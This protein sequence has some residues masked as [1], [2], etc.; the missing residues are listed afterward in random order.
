MNSKSAR[1][2]HRTPR[3]IALQ[4]LRTMQATLVELIRPLTQPRTEQVRVPGQLVQGT[5]RVLKPGLDGGWVDEPY[6]YT[7]V[8]WVRR[9]RDPTTLPEN[10]ADYWDGVWRAAQQLRMQA[11][12]IG[13]F[14]AEQAKIA[15]VR[16]HP[17]N[18]TPEENPRWP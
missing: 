17:A 16:Q 14:A 2:P 7:E 1:G 5:R 11:D 6:E 10:T 4:H 18:C 3:L 9:R 13:R 8:G 12:Q 15:R